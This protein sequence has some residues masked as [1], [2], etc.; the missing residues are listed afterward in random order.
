LFLI[1]HLPLA[2]TS[3]KEEQMYRLLHKLFG[4]HYVGYMYG[5]RPSK[6]RIRILDNDIVL[7]WICCSGYVPLH[8]VDSET[9]RTLYP[10]TMSQELFKK[11]L[12]DNDNG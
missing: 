11:V 7:V 3:L 1:H 10:L 8:L 2:V 4:W 9:K 12:E 5:G 6:G